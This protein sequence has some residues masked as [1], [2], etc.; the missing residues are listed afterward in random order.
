MLQKDPQKRFSI[1]QIRQH[2]FIRFSGKQ[3]IPKGINT[4]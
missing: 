2:D 3:H 1:D 4:K